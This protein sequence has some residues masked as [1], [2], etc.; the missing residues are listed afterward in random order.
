[1]GRHNFSTSTLFF[2]VFV[3]RTVIFLQAAISYIEGKRKTSLHHTLKLQ[4]ALSVSQFLQLYA[5]ICLHIL[6]PVVKLTL[7]ILWWIALFRGCIKREIVGQTL[8]GDQL[9]RATC[10]QLLVRSECDSRHN[11]LWRYRNGR[12]HYILSLYRLLFVIACM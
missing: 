5:C 1:M 9:K 2:V 11:I 6:S 7:I 12:Q 3:L 10:E 4:T 8:R